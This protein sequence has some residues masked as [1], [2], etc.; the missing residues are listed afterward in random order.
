M[1]VWNAMSS[2]TLMILEMLAEESLI[3]NYG[4]N[5]FFHLVIALSALSLVGTW[6]ARRRFATTVLLGLGCHLGDGGRGAPQ[7][8]ACSVEP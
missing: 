8:L 5:H 4:V 7:W 3:S 2:M 1:L 6:G